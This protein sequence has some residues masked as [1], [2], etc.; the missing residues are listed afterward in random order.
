V[1]PD[2]RDRRPAVSETANT[3]ADQAA[4]SIPQRTDIERARRI[5]RWAIR[6]LDAMCGIE[7]PELDG[8]QIDYRAT[9]LDLDWGQRR[10]AGLALL[11]AE[12]A[13]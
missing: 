10:A 1:P 13:A 12:R 3:Q 2:E 4:S 5:R 7:R 11:A 8:V 6:E 9:G